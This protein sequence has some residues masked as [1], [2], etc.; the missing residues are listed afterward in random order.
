VVR[1]GDGT[2]A[3]FSH[4]RM[5]AASNATCGPLTKEL[6]Q[7]DAQT[8]LDAKRPRRRRARRGRPVIDTVLRRR[9]G[10]NRPQ[11]GASRRGQ[12]THRAGR[13]VHTEAMGY[14]LAELQSV[15]RA[16]PG[17]D[18]VTAAAAAYDGAAGTPDPELAH[19]H[20]P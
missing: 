11:S 4:S 10:L 3:L 9:P 6:F 16:Y 12:R 2:G 14:I 20:R 17:R 7:P 5:Q 8:R 18:M 19:G 1:L 15:A 13:G